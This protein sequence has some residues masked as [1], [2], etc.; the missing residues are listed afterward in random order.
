MNDNTSEQKSLITSLEAKEKELNNE[1]SNLEEFLFGPFDEPS[2]DDGYEEYIKQQN[3]HPQEIEYN[4][5]VQQLNRVQEELGNIKRDIFLEENLTN[6]VKNSTKVINSDSL[7]RDKLAQNLANLIKEQK[8]DSN[9]SIGILG[10]WGSGKTTFLNLIKKNLEPSDTVINFDASQYDDQEQIWYSLLST[11]SNKY[12]SNGNEFSQKVKFIRKVLKEKKELS[13]IFMP[14]FTILILVILLTFF[15]MSIKDFSKT[16]PILQSFLAVISTGVG[17]I[18]LESI[19]KSYQ[20]LEKYFVSRNEQLLK[21]LKYPDYRKLLGTRDNVRTELAIFKDLIITKKTNQKNIVIMIDELDRCSEE[22]IKNF[23][24]SIDAFIDIPGIIF[25]FSF[26]PNIVYPA[27]ARISETE[28]NP[29][30]NIGVEFVEKYIN[31]FFTLPSVIS[32]KNYVNSLLE[33]ISTEN[34]INDLSKLIDFIS[35]IKEISPREVKKLL[36]LSLI[37]HKEFTNFCYSEFSIV[38]IL[39]YYFSIFDNLKKGIIDRTQFSKLNSYQLRKVIT[40][41]F[42]DDLLKLTIK[43]LPDINIETLNRN[44]S[45][46]NKILK[47]TKY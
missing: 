38:L 13:L 17:Y 16:N 45:E 33:G 11:V 35:N 31:L 14:L 1:I 27:V 41:D 10:E 21:Q 42:S 9:L 43:L 46:I 29:N 2:F 7:E 12:L 22:T 6:I 3:Q 32:Y 15:L 5:K 8:Q 44:I 24:S 39:Q 18:A 34:D 20:S 4:R 36:D 40:N 23:F 47:Y 25:I 28:Q 37:Y 26:N 30:N 19:K